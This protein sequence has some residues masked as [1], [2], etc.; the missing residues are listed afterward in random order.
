MFL[1][2]VYKSN[3]I[4]FRVEL[5][6]VGSF[7]Q[8]INVFCLIKNV[9]FLWVGSDEL[10]APAGA[11]ENK[12]AFN[13]NNVCGQSDGN[14]IPDGTIARVLMRIKKGG[15]NSPEKGFTGDYATLNPKTGVSYLKCTGFIEEG[16]YAKRRI[17]FRIGLDSPNSPDYQIMGLE[18]MRSIVDSAHGLMPD[19]ESA[20]AM[21]KRQCDFSDLDGLTFTARIDVEQSEAKAKDRN[22]IN[23]AITPDSDLYIGKSGKHKKS[24]TA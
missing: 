22:V 6:H 1:E 10:T 21:E 18:F 15:H 9:F 4:L 7:L 12:M 5:K 2:I 20:E 8:A 3:Y 13:L 11:E 24:K 14:L 23:Y 16:D 19:D 17:F